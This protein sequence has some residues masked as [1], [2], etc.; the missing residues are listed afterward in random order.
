MD[1]G[2]LLFIIL[3]L[4]PILWNINECKK[5]KR[6]IFLSTILSTLFITIVWISFFGWMIGIGILSSLADGLKIWQWVPIYIFG[7]IIT[8]I[9]TVFLVLPFSNAY[10]SYLNTG[11]ISVG[12][13]L[14][15]IIKNFFKKY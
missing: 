11:K 10:D 2:K 8:L 12:F 5:K 9:I 4:G 3:W 6:N 14:P 1:E 13:K 15:K 7:S